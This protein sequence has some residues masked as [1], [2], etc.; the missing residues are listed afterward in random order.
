MT[1]EAE[2]MTAVMALLEA[3]GALPYTIQDA[4]RVSVL[5]PAYSEVVIMRRYGGV[6]RNGM[7]RA[8]GY[9][10]TV[11]ACGRTYEQAVEMRRL[12]REAL[13]DSRL[14]VDGR[15][16]TPIQFEDEEAVDN[17]ETSRSGASVEWYFGASLY[18][19]VY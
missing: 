10:V 6:F 18:T 2:Q 5:P 12:A 1:H 11:R 16:T 17:T 13:E 3:G 4:K 15:T 14:T 7:T 8:R 9:R 19:Y